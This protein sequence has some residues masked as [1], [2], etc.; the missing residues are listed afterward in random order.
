[1][2]SDPQPHRPADQPPVRTDRKPA[3]RVL[4][5]ERSIFWSAALVF[6]VAVIVVL[7]FLL[8]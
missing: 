7:Y 6:A 4:G 3:L 8:R 5:L 1:M 2:R